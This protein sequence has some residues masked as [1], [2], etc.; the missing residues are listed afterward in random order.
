MTA[1]L[2]DGTKGKVHDKARLLLLVVVSGD[3]SVNL[4]ANQGEY[5]QAFVIGCQAI[6]SVPSGTI[7]HLDSHR[8]LGDSYYRM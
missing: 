3:N 6:V 8:I 2:K 4:K 1:L 5:D 7:S